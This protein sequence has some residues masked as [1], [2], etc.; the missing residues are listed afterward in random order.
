MTATSQAIAETSAHVGDHG[1]AIVPAVFTPAEAARIA[2]IAMTVSTH[3]MRHS[4]DGFTVDRSADGTAEAPRKIDYPFQKHA[5]FR[6]FVLDPRLTELAA[7][8]LGGPAHLMR[9]QLFCKPPGFGSAKPYH[10]ENASLGYEPP[11]AMIVTWIALD[12]ATADNGCLRVIDG[13]HHT[14][15]PHQAQPGAIYNHLPPA[16]AIDLD[17]EVLLP[18]PAGAVVVLHSQVLHYS[19][20][21][22]SPHWRRAYTAHW[23]TAAA[24]CTTA[25]AR[26]GYS[27][28]TGGDNQLIHRAP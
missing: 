26:Y 17:R 6:A 20:P 22:P 16:E 14:L 27:H 11:E 7:A 12:D 5:E 28:T 13:S 21:N 19:A 23:V 15:W 4:R 2:E 9:D 3:E 10:Q 18:V 25:A 1:Y 8:V 24:T